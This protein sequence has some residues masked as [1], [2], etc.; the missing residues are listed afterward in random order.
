MKK[1]EAIIRPE[2]L[3][4]VKLAL[5]N[6]GFVGMNI[7]HVTGR[8]VQKGIVH[9]GR[10]GETYTVDMLPKLKIEVVV[11]DPDVKQAVDLIMAAARTGNIGDGKIFIIP[12]ENAIRV[13]TGEQGEIAV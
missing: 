11:K 10:G 3:N 1:I 8:G 13:R 4:E 6:A 12:V 9:G 5:E 7:V 2:K